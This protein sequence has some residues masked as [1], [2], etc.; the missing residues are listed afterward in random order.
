MTPCSR[1]KQHKEKKTKP[2]KCQNGSLWNSRRFLSQ[3]PGVTQERLFPSHHWFPSALSVG[4]LQRRASVRQSTGANET[5]DGELGNKRPNKDGLRARPSSVYSEQRSRSSG[6]LLPGFNPLRNLN[7][8]FLISEVCFLSQ[9]NML[10]ISCVLH[11]QLWRGT[12]EE[13]ARLRPAPRQ[14]PPRSESALL[15]VLLPSSLSNQI[16]ICK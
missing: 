10:L 4:L 5:G 1:N 15:S 6:T 3:S 16:F 14:R 8:F 9:P 2:G 13:P 12:D 7:L 11:A